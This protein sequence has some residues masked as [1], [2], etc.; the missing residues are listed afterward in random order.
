[1]DLSKSH[2]RQESCYIGEGWAF[3]RRRLGVGPLQPF[4]DYHLQKELITLWRNQADG[5]LTTELD[6]YNKTLYLKD[7]RVHF[8]N[9]D[10][11]AE[12]LPNV[13]IQQGRFTQEQFEQVEPNFSDAISV[14]RNLIEMGLISQQELAQ[15]GKEQVYQI[16]AN[17]FLATSGNYDF[18]EGPLPE[19]VVSLPPT[20]PDCFFRAFQGFDNKTWLANQF[21]ADLNFIPAHTDEKPSFDKLEHAGPAGEIYG[22]IDGELD[23]NHLAFEV[24]VDDFVLLKSLYLMQLMGY[25]TI[26]EQEPEE[27]FEIPEVVTTPDAGEETEDTDDIPVPEADDMAAELSAVMAHNDELEQLG[28][29]SMEETVQLPKSLVGDDEEDP[30]LGMDVTMEIPR[31]QVDLGDDDADEIAPFAEEPDDDALPSIDEE[32]D[33]EAAAAAFEDEDEDEPGLED[34]SDMGAD[35]FEQ[36]LAQGGDEELDGETSREEKL[37][38][39]IMPDDE[40]E[41]DFEEA[42]EAPKGGGGRLLV[43]ISALFFVFSGWLLMEQ[44]HKH[45]LAR[46]FPS[47]EEDIPDPEAELALV[48]SET[49]TPQDPQPAEESTAP[50]TVPE[51]QAPNPTATPDTTVAETNPEPPPQD[52]PQDTQTQETPEP[53]PEQGVAAQETP[54]QPPANMVP[55]LGRRPNS[56]VGFFSPVAE[57]WDPET[58]KPQDDSQSYASPDLPPPQALDAEAQKVVDAKAGPDASDT[59]QTQTAPVAA[60]TN[61]PAS[62]AEAP[63]RTAV[64]SGDPDAA[65]AA[66]NFNRAAQL[67]RDRKAPQGNR[68][69]LALFMVC[70]EAS[71]R[72]TVREAGA[73]AP[74]FLLPRTYRGQSCWWVCWGDF[75]SYRQAIDAVDTMP[76]AIRAKRR[77][78][79]VRTVGELTNREPSPP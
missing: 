38:G 24:D 48:E 35:L 45:L 42:E 30:G 37:A 18:E 5:V 11:P 13:L 12:K 79:E 33:A 59:P 21:G 49:E 56:E 71:I 19:G 43:L 62:G 31:D 1:M 36:K 61:R 63:S 40:D 72:Q 27:D 23:Y 46:Y 14:G 15:G 44:P 58:G 66:G 39:V 57:G 8:A 47:G 52:P 28:E 22:L 65:F 4:S 78:F 68:Y 75:D 60:N 55:G 20:Y 25:L 67:W 50:A 41:E 70:Q 69:T 9:S 77:Q 54:A 10:D 16:F 7:G 2:G 53:E 3:C 76:E 64:P 26:E 32:V 73:G 29:M 34:L 51:T 74:L 17:V 6:G